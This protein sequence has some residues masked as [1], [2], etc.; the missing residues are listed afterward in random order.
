M[1]L[2]F[3][4][5]LRIGVSNNNVSGI[6]FL[7]LSTPPWVSVALKME[8][9]CS[10]LWSLKSHLYHKKSVQE[11]FAHSLTIVFSGYCFWCENRWGSL[12][13]IAKG[14]VFCTKPSFP[15]AHTL[16][17]IF[18][19]LKEWVPYSWKQRPDH[20]SVYPSP[21]GV[22]ETLAWLETHE[23]TDQSPSCSLKDDWNNSI[24]LIQ[25]ASLW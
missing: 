2:A 8:H 9:C 11:D 18:C 25:T 21:E 6:I 17:F 10:E 19:S 15:S 14:T 5:F 12:S 7:E 22:R 3:S 13:L 23:K 16:G 4:T 24:W 20:C 1:L